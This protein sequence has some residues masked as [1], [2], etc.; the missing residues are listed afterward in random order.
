MGRPNAHA[1]IKGGAGSRVSGK[2]SFFSQN[3]GSM[4]TAQIYGLPDGGGNCPGGVYN[5]YIGNGQ[6]S[7]SGWGNFVS[8]QFFDNGCSRN[9][10]AGEMPT[11]VSNNGYAMMS[12]F[13]PRY[14]PSQVIGRSV[15]ITARDNYNTVLACGNIKKN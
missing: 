10:R 7:Q 15:V 13:T 11:L 3:G 5:I 14:T 2:V 9:L 4:V 8:P 6:C 1:D 12:Y